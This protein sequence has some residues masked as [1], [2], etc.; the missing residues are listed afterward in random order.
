MNYLFEDHPSLLL[1]TGLGSTSITTHSSGNNP[2]TQSYY[3]WGEKRYP[4]GA[5]ALP[6]T[7]QFTGQRHEK[8]LGP[9]GSEGLYYYGARW[10]KTYQ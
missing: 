6:T 4:T 3:P 8:E 9:A 5:P 7:F 2:I 10:Y 1:G